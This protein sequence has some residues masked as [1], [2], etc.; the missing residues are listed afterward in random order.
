MHVDTIN[1]CITFIETVMYGGHDDEEYVETR[2]RLYKRQ[3][4]KTSLSLPPDPNSCLQAVLRA[5]HQSFQWTRCL[6]KNIEDI[7]MLKNGWDVRKDGCSCMVLRVP[8]ILLLSRV[9]RLRLVLF[10]NLEV[11]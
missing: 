8:N 2:I 4:K 7:D 9:F 1:K 10:P 5:N 6:E 11:N 3:N